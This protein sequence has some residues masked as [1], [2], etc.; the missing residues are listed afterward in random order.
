MN[1]EVYSFIKLASKIASDNY[2]EILG[3][4]FIVNAP[5]FFTGIW[6]MVKIFI[7]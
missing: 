3:R 2:P 7:D 4:M 5:I 1:K 6:A